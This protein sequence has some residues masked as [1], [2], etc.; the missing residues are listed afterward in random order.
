MSVHAWFSPVLHMFDHLAL[1]SCDFTS[2]TVHVPS[3]ASQMQ[4]IVYINM[5][6]KSDAP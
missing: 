1:F 3:S 4:Y 5:V 6:S 2:M